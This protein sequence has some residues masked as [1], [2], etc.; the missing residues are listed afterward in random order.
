MKSEVK[1]KS[2]TP[3][4]NILQLKGKHKKTYKNKCNKETKHTSKK[5]QKQI[6]KKA[7]EGKA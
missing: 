3:S 2:E 5:K 4:S 1:L 7:W 6:K